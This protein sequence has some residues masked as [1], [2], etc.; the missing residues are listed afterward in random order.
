MH[1]TLWHA[2]CGLRWQQKHLRYALL[3]MVL[4]ATLS[5]VHRLFTTVACLFATVSVSETKYRALTRGYFANTHNRVFSERE[6]IDNRVRKISIKMVAMY[7]VPLLIRNCSRRLLH[8]LTTG[9]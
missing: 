5:T 9:P 1:A 3:P 2:V 7:S 4:G 6:G 8:A